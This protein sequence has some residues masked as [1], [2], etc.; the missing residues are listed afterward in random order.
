MTSRLHIDDFIARLD[1]ARQRRPNQWMALCPAHDD[2]RPSLLVETGD[3]GRLLVYCY[4]G[5]GAAEVVAA[6][7]LRLA[8]LFP[9]R[10]ADDQRRHIRHRPTIEA[11]DVID[12]LDRERLL[13]LT[14]AQDVVSG[15]TLKAADLERLSLAGHRMQ[16]LREIVA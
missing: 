8:D 1:G 15:K 13:V 5:C 3:D 12:A 6:V 16:R 2:K 14:I 4:A 9:K 7:G 10:E 11:R